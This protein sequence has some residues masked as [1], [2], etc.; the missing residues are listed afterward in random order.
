MKTTTC[1]QVLASLRA[2]RDHHL[3]QIKVMRAKN[4]ALVK[5]VEEI[6]RQKADWAANNPL[7]LPIQ[8]GLSANL[9]SSSSDGKFPESSA[10]SLIPSLQSTPLTYQNG[11][12]FGGYKSEDEHLIISKSP[13]GRNRIDI[14]YGGSK[15]GGGPISS[16]LG[17]EFPPLGTITS[18]NVEGSNSNLIEFSDTEPTAY[19]TPKGSGIFFTPDHKRQDIYSP[20]PFSAQSTPDHKPLQLEIHRRIEEYDSLLQLLMRKNVSG[21]SSSIESPFSGAQPRSGS[22]SD[23]TSISESLYRS[24]SKVPKND[25]VVIEELR[26][27]NTQLRQLIEKLFNDSDAVKRE[28]EMLKARLDVQ[29]ESNRQLREK[30]LALESKL[31]KLNLDQGGDAPS[32]RKSSSIAASSSQA[33]SHASP[34]LRNQ[35]ASDVGYPRKPTDDFPPLDRPVL[36]Y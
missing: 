1:E 14:V 28:N 13:S 19:G 30:V 23:S 18:T 21:S 16:D 7:F 10:S 31:S 8:E 17:P 11:L 32:S 22:I 2:Q 4:D 9:P 35:L 6:R 33:S 36:Y 29:E 12:A 27:N 3:L 26:M 24:A 5:K 34:H 15:G 20:S 25:K